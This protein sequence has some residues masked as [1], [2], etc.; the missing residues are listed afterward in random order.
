[1]KGGYDG[2]NRLND[3]IRFNFSTDDDFIC[4]VPES[5]FLSD[6]KAFVNNTC[7]SDITFLVEN[8]PVYAHKLLLSRCPYFEAMFTCE[9][10]ESSQKI[11]RIEEVRQISLHSV[12]TFFYQT[13]LF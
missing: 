3:F 6:L 8:Q 2:F 4:D 9:M 7:M 12:D 5:T 10:L 13:V 11:I 1:M